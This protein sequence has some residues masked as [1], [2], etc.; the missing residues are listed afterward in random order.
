M[1]CPQPDGKRVYVVYEQRAAGGDTSEASVLESFD[2]QDDRRAK[3]SA[4]RFWHHLPYVLYGY[5]FKNG[6]AI[7]D[8]RPLDKHW[9]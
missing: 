8:D 7:E 4:R 2:D 6:I 1:K 3:R 5:T 9:S